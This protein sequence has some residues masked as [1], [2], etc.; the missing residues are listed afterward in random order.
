MMMPMFEY[1]TFECEN[2]EQLQAMLTQ[3]GL[4]RWRLHTCEPIITGG[5]YGMG[6][7]KILVVMDRIIEEPEGEL[8]VSEAVDSSSAGLAMIG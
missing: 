4:A 6:M 1:F 7:T 3:A 2:A 8:E 5:T